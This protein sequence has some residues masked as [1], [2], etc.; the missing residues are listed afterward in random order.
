MN[1]AKIR[2][3]RPFARYGAGDVG[4]ITGDCGCV[5]NP[6]WI[7]KMFDGNEIQLSKRITK[8]YERYEVIDATA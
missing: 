5:S 4:T 2:L 8:G 6:R 1:G 3:L 7:I